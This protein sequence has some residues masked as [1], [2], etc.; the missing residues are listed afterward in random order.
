M[1]TSSAILSL[2]V[3]VLAAAGMAAAA[4]KAP[5]KAKRAAALQAVVD[6]R[7]VTDRDARLACY[8]KAAASLDEAESSGQVVVVD[9]EQARQVRRE[10]FG[11]QL[12]SLDIFNLAGGGKAAS[13]IA[14]GDDV[15]R[16]AATVK[17][18]FREGS[19]RW[20]IELDTGAVW[21]QI[22]DSDV[23]VDARAGSKVEI[24]RASLG[25]FFLK[26]DGQPA[27]KA[28]RDR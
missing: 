1:K 25:S 26:V 24:R 8:D 17:S 5:S 10:V 15:D 16:L 23:Q 28:H 12:P 3:A 14:K 4:G 6:C 27:F 7:A 13:A 21:R 11:L 22:E 18:A 19:G 20:V 2:S 9:R